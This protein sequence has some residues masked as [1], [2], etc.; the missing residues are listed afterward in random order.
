MP[1][2]ELLQGVRA[3]S[4][5]NQPKLSRRQFA[6]TVAATLAAP[7][8]LGGLFPPPKAGAVPRPAEQKKPEVK[9]PATA[10]QQPEDWRERALKA[11]QEFDVPIET[12]PAFVFQAAWKPQRR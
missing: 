3:M 2:T 12:E 6:G 10:D 5:N 11:I 4:S 8:L 7:A 9:K 1:R